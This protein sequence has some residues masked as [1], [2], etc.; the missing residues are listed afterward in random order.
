MTHSYPPQANLAPLLQFWLAAACGGDAEGLG[1]LLE[2]SQPYLLLLATAGLPARLQAKLSP[3]DLVQ[4]TFLEAYRDFAAFRGR[5]G[6]ELLGWLRQMLLNNLTSAVR[7]YQAQCR[8]VAREQPLEGCFW[9]GEV[10]QD[11][12]PLADTPTPFSK[13]VA[14]EEHA[15]LRTAVERLPGHYRQVLWLR[16]QE[17]HSFAD[18]GTVLKTSAEAA[19]KLW[20]RAVL[21]LRQEL[22]M[23]P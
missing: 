2:I 17:G 10:R 11:G 14:Q 3:A 9:A 4:E 5:T 12:D 23:A 18:I 19:R 6:A 15:L 16:H 8:D 22:R 20:T 13:A 21:R 7:R 1:R